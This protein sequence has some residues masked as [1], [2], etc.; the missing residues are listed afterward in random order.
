MHLTRLLVSG[1]AVA[2]MGASF[3]ALTAVPASADEQSITFVSG[4]FRTPDGGA[5]DCP[6][7]PEGTDCQIDKFF[8]GI[9]GADDGVNPGADDKLTTVYIHEDVPATG[10]WQY[11]DLEEITDVRGVFRG[12]EIGIIDARP[13]LSTTGNFAAVYSGVTD[14]GCYSLHFVINGTID[15]SG[16]V[17]QSS[18][19]VDIDSGNWT[20]YITSHNC[21]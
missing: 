3:V 4:T 14:D 12:H 9:G 7:V 8:G 19:P 15:I 16:I 13:N 21:S 11:N 5:A 2:I 20:G 1:L 17:S 6:G 18:N 10:F